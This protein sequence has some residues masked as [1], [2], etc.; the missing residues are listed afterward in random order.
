M[1]GRKSE[2]GEAKKN[3]VTE[4]GKF[5]GYKNVHND[6]QEKRVWPNCSACGNK[7]YWM[8]SFC[9]YFGDLEK[10]CPD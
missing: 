10:E 7:L 6:G 8:F 5:W 3:Y 1:D 2:G 9:Q 4:S